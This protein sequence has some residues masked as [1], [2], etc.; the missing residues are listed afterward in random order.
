MSVWAC[1]CGGVTFLGLVGIN[2]VG[3]A[4][5]GRQ[6]CQTG[7]EMCS[8]QNKS[9]S[10][11]QFSK[12]FLQFRFSNERT[13]HHLWGLEV[14]D[15]CVSRAPVSLHHYIY[16]LSLGKKKNLTPVEKEN[17]CEF[18]R[19]TVRFERIVPAAFVTLCVIICDCLLLCVAPF[20]IQRR[21]CHCITSVW[22]HYRCSL[23]RSKHISYGLASESRGR[24]RDGERAAS[25]SWSGS[26]SKQINA[27]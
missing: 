26:V 12:I 13:K 6:S 21:N 22:K 10:S 7:K 2:K 14:A 20:W 19:Y 25:R 3:R 27:H 17:N 1:V 15:V 18:A 23:W 11:Q 16:F 4:V 8:H 24:G 5:R 9:I